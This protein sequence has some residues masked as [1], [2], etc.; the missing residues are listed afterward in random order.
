VATSREKTCFRATSDQGSEELPS[1]QAADAILHEVPLAFQHHKD[2][3][4]TT[5]PDAEPSY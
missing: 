5:G 4:L 3:V 2:I 1:G